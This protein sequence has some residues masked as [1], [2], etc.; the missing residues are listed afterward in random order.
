MARKKTPTLNEA[1]LKLMKII[2]DLDNATVNEVMENLP[3][4]SNLAYNTVLTTLRI[5]EDK[6]YLKH[7]KNGRAH[8]YSALVSK[9]QARQSVVRHMVQSFFNN[10]PELLL[11]SLIENENMSKTDIEAIKE[12]IN[13]QSGSSDGSDI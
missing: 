6:C 7:S 3:K 8:V 5:L 10:S 2:W 12:M 1:E 4:D 13:K 9:D 11:V